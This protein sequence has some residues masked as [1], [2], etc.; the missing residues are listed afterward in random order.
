M[1]QGSGVKVAV[2]LEEWLD[3]RGDRGFLKTVLWVEGTPLHLEAVEVHEGGGG[4][5]EAVVRQDEE[6]L[7]ALEAAYAARWETM[8]LTWPG[9]ALP[10]AYV[11]YAVP[12]GR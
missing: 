12:F 10:R 9:D 2:P 11:A 7:E 4:L 3:V 5:L 6:R 1:T 8:P